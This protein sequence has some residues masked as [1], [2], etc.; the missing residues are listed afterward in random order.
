MNK[1]KIIMRLERLI[2]AFLI[3]FP[4][5]TACAAFSSSS[6][7][8]PVVKWPFDVSKR[9]SKVNQEFRIR[10]YRNY[11]FAL[12]FDYFGYAD[13]DRV[14]EQLVGDGQSHYPGINIPIHIKIFKLDTGG[15]PPELKYEDTI[16]T[17]H[18]YAQAYDRIQTDGNFLR[19]IA[20]V[21]LKPG[22]YRVEANTIEERPEFSGTP[23]YLKIGWHPKTTTIKE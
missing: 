9:D 1:N 7:P 13:E 10:E 15:L 12:R 3:L 11:I 18:H 6:P 2:L 20:V 22:I 5:V 8:T 23:S 16:L 19:Y 14:F 21:A 4:W 17:K